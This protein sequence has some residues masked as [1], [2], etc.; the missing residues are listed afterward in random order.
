MAFVAEQRGHRRR[1]DP[2]LQREISPLRDLARRPAAR[3][4]DPRDRPHVLHTHTAKAGTVG[5]AR[6][7][8]RGRRAATGRRPHLPRPHAARRL[9][10]RRASACT[11]RSSGASRATPTRSSP[12]A[13]RCATSSSRSASRRLRGSRSSASGSSSP[14]GWQGAERGG[15]L[16]ASLGISPERFTVGWVGADDR[17]QAAGPTSCARSALLRDRG[18]DAA[19]V[20]VGDGPDRAALEALAR[21]LGIDDATPLRRLPG[22][23]RPVVPRLRRPAPALA[24]RGNAG[25][26]D[27]DAR[28]RAAGRRHATSAVSRTSCT[29]ASTASSSRSATSR[30]PPS[31][32]RC[33]PRDPDAPRSGWAPPAG[34]RALAATGCRGSSRTSTASTAR[35]SPRRGSRSRQGAARRR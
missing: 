2:R 10:P 9:R 4:A 19:L 22:R 32:S 30:R 12:S 21:E 34:A 5:P 7:P 1:V 23:R 33:S 11:G 29:T 20:M 14:S 3:G 25:E 24:E 16:R 15:E 8:S 35:S 26:R 13:P 28:V 17:G 18:V 6:G 31:G 27:R